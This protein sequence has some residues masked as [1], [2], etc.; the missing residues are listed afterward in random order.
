MQKRSARQRAK[1][2]LAIMLAKAASGTCPEASMCQLCST[3]CTDQGLWTVQER[4]DARKRARQER[5]HFLRTGQRV[6]WVHLHRRW[7]GY[8]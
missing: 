2:L 5:L 1:L 6:D 3:L 8:M 4:N 7:M